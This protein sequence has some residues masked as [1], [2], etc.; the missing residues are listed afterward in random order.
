EL[1]RFVKPDIVSLIGTMALTLEGAFEPYLSA[2][3]VVFKTA[4]VVTA[5]RLCGGAP[6]A[7]TIEWVSTLRVKI[8]DAYDAI[9]LSLRPSGMQVLQYLDQLLDFVRAVWTDPD[10]SDEAVAR[11]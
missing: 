4:G 11:C 9:F 6:D 1:K 10:R 3:M 7:E 2:V 8:A 5:Q